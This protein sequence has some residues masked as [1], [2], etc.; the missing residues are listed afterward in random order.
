MARVSLIPFKMEQQID[1]TSEIPAGIEMMQAP[2]KWEEGYKGS[3]VVVAVIDTGCDRNHPDLRNRIMDGRNFTTENNSNL[4]NFSDQNGH[5]T[6]VAGTIAAVLNGR[7]VVGV[8][9]E[10]KLLILKAFD[11]KGSGDFN[12]IIQ[13]IQ[14]AIKWR[15]GNGEKVR[16]I[17]MSFGAKW[18]VPELHQVIR[19]AVTNDILVVCAAG[20]EGDGDAR[21]TERMYP[22]YYKE[23]VQVGAVDNEGNMAEFTNTNDE[24]DL[25][26]PG[27]NVMSTYLN[28]KY[29]KLSGTSMATPHVSGA[30]AVL[31]EQME[32]EFERTLTEPEVYAQ[33]IKLTSPLGYSKRVE[34]NGL[35]TLTNEPVYRGDSENPKEI[36]SL[37]KAKNNK[38]AGSGF[39]IPDV[40]V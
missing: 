23:V 22:G 25:V 14:H 31:I 15:G 27:V 20:N 10:A 18:D 24:V 33:L 16:I 7:G 19:K 8:A 17:S 5:G 28:G 6:H 21:T 30:A 11:A 39:V 34:S 26:A 4:R 29:A 2:K 32:Q 36:K 37:S 40:E 3:D 12:G 13:A 1:D 38:M 35:I 9:P